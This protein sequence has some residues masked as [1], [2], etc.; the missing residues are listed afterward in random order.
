V[1]L[2]QFV[3]IHTPGSATERHEIVGAEARIG[4]GASCTIRPNNAAAFQAEH[5]RLVPSDAG[6][7]VGLMP[8]AAGTLMHAGAPQSEF[9]VPWGDEVFL[10]GV[11]FTFLL[12]AGQSGRPRPALLAV[13]AV[14]LTLTAV[15][16]ARSSDT[17][18]VSSRE[19]EPPALLQHSAECPE[20]DL[21]RVDAVAAQTERS[22]LAKE[23]RSAF[24][25]ADGAQALALLSESEAC[26]RVAGKVEDSERIRAEL[27]RWTARMNEEY[28]AARL[29]LRLALEHQRWGEALETVEH[30]Q[31]LLVDHAKE[32]YTEWLTGLRNE[33]ERKVV[34]RPR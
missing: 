9:V 6:C 24:M 1:I 19:L 17:E 18:D 16:F 10:G 5:V 30:V 3:E 31:A 7:R 26:Y 12:E 13:A 4:S 23:E 28:A 29:L 33:L 34:P 32:P 11:R 14:V 8:G 25:V 27:L 22:A 15:V 2:K 20:S 21:T